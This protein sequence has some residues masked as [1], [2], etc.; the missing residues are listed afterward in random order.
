MAR[1]TEGE[2]VIEA[3]RDRSERG[4]VAWL[5][6]WLA[7]RLAVAAEALTPE[8]PFAE[9]G[10]DSREAV[11]LAGELAAT[12]GLTLPATVFLDRPNIAELARH[13]SFLTSSAPAIGESAARSGKTSCLL[14]LAGGRA[15]R[16][17]VVI[18][19]IFGMLSAFTAL[20]TELGR[21]MPLWGLDLPVHRGLSTPPS[22]EELAERYV[23]DLVAMPVGGAYRIAGYCTGGMVAIEVVRQLEQ[24]GRSVERLLLLDAP[25]L[26]AEDFAFDKLLA[27]AAR[28]G[29]TAATPEEAVRKVVRY[30]VGKNWSFGQGQDFIERMVAGGVANLTTFQR[31]EP[32]PVAIPTSLFSARER[33]GLP[34]YEKDAALNL[35]RWTRLLGRAPTHLDITGNHHSML[36]PPHVAELSRLLIEELSRS[37][38]PR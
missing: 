21:H 26:G 18:P 12:L 34:L 10:L 35:A 36:Q 3:P 8:V 25:C 24:R 5:T 9:L 32:R 19:G 1:R 13:L 16:P 22:I 37:S 27:D 7:G 33:I 6:P 17:L 15:G 11:G 20:V 4:L 28:A 23:D 38:E 14:S 2:A 30:A 29:L 31:W